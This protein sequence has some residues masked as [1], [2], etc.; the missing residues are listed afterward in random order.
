MFDV[1]SLLEET[2]APEQSVGDEALLRVDPV[3]NSV[4]VEAG[5]GREHNN[6]EQASGLSEELREVGTSLVLISNLQWKVFGEEIFNIYLHIDRPPAN[7]RN[8]QVK[9][10]I[11]IWDKLE[12]TVN[13]CLIQVKHQG[14]L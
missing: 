9:L 1:S 2:L 3:N 7:V 6:L 12:T 8:L 14:L 5:G 11:C 10:N 4:A 13:Q